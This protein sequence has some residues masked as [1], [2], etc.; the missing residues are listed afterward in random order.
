MTG[1]PRSKGCEACRKQKKKCDQ[2]Q[3]ACSRCTRLNIACIGPGERRYKFVQVA[4]TPRSGTPETQPAASSSPSIQTG[5]RSVSRPGAQEVQFDLSAFGRF[6]QLLPQKAYASQALSTSMDAFFTSFTDNG[7]QEH[8]I[9][10][11]QKYG[12]AIAT[13]RDCLNVPETAETVETLCAIYLLSVSQAWGPAQNTH[14]V[15]HE[16]GLVYILERMA[17]RGIDVDFEAEIFGT[18]CIPLMLSGMAN[19]RVRLSPL[20]HDIATKP[21]SPRRTPPTSCRP[22]SVSTNF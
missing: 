3:P 10:W 16:E 8:S 19:P 9:L 6:L 5:G 18:I 15:S 22:C 21:A 14:L 13:L 20:A 12:T 1:V 11:H 7:S 4:E 17:R 2:K